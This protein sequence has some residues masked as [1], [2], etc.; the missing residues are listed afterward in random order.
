MKNNLMKRGAVSLFAAVAL[1]GS[2][3][4]VQ[5]CWDENEWE[6]IPNGPFLQIEETS[7]NFDSQ[8][9][10]YQMT[11]K[12]NEDYVVGFGGGL[13]TWCT[14]TKDEMGDLTLS[15]AENPDKDVRR[16]ELYIQAVSQTDTIP[17]A[18]L[19]WGKAI[20]LSPQAISVPGSGG[21][22]DLDV[23]ANVEYELVMPDVDWLSEVP[24]TQ[25]R[26]HETVTTHHRFSVAMNESDIRT[27]S[28]IV[29]D[30]D[31][32]S[33]IEP[34]E[35]VVTQMKMGD[36]EP[37]DPQLNEDILIRADAVTGDG[38]E[39]SAGFPALIDGNFETLWQCAWRNGVKLPQYLEFTFN[40]PTDMDYLIYYAGG[41]TTYWKDV[42]VQVYSD[43]N[44]T[45]AADYRTVYTGT[46]PNAAS[47][48]IDFAESQVNVTKVKIIIKSLN[49]AT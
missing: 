22:F 39:T 28:I 25:T 29:K 33:M 44:V 15:I 1:F 27:A 3:L 45:R 31:A 40:E 42:E 14:A 36:Y 21:T 8:A 17:V 43:V 26:A 11:V 48:R 19:G 47:A 4:L 9:T 49:S 23:T 16:G 20:L 38:G 34:V 10:E 5:S 35:F 12:C 32:I 41:P 37:L 30:K 6:G 7:L 24:F 2:S 13:D 18:Q 46:L